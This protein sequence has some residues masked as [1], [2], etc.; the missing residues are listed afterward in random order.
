M[1]S[2]IW[3]GLG[4]IALATPL[5]LLA[6]LSGRLVRRP[7][8][9]HGLWVLV[10]LKLVTPPLGFVPVGSLDEAWPVESETSVPVFV[11][12][13][14]EGKPLAAAPVLMLPA[15][16]AAEPAPLETVSNPREDEVATQVIA[17]AQDIGDREHAPE[18]TVETA[19]LSPVAEGGESSPPDAVIGFGANFLSWL[20]PSL[21]GMWL[22]GTLV[23][24]SRVLRNSYRFQKLLAEAMI[25]PEDLK[26]RVARLAAELKVSVPKVVFVTGAISPLLWV[27]GRR[28]A[29]VLPRP[30]FEQLDAEQQGTLIVHELAHWKRGDHWVRRL[31][32]L[33]SGLYWW[34]PLVWW[35]QAGVRQAEE[36]CCDAWVTATVPGS[37]RAYALALV[38]TVDFLAGARTL[39]P[40]LA[41][42]LGPF[43]SLQRRLTMIFCKGT[44]KRLSLAGL[45]GLV[46]LGGL[47]LTWS[48]MP[49]TVRAQD[50]RPKTER[51]PLG[52]ESVGGGAASQDEQPPRPKKVKDLPGKKTPS[53][54]R[55]PDVLDDSRA[56][57]DRL[58]AELRALRDQHER[59]SRD[60][61]QRSRELQK[62][63]DEAGPGPRPGAGA[64]QAD[65]TPRPPTGRGGFNEAPPG[66][67][68]A[69]RNGGNPGFGGGPPMM[70]SANLPGN[71]V[72]RRID[73]LER[74][75][76]K[77]LQELV[78]MR[79]EMSNRGG[80]GGFGGGF[81]GGGGGS[82]FGGGGQGAGFGGGGG[83]QGGFKKGP[84]GPPPGS[85]P[86]IQPVPPREPT[87]PVA[88]T[89][90]TQRREKGNV[91]SD[92]ERDNQNPKVIRRPGAS[93]SG[94]SGQLPRPN[95]GADEGH[96][97]V[98]VAPRRVEDRGQPAKLTN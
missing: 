4:N 35:A 42:G 57:L 39:L 84:A 93:T 96:G 67:P 51:R 1:T 34:C 62:R 41:S 23:F 69:A 14:T 22:G 61:D 63:S 13:P 12:A 80:G 91:E 19:P 2:L 83:F 29:L 37:E 25:A 59:L 3:L 27:S 21:G 47:L 76:D 28:A 65:P 77:M 90:P 56:E 10:L 72:E 43:P 6:W 52:I 44:P 46:G 85:Q 70:P 89:P 81:P 82:G 98:P 64:P 78:E 20:I 15:P 92:D 86:Q 55:N 79:R 95:A 16:A 74:K 68:P 8:L 11:S 17:P 30:L 31:E 48:P 53:P 75:L 7:A 58:R 18:P 9:T 60:I 49:Q 26:A 40:T 5:A 94:G 54:G 24:W 73:N 97:I 66:F 50:D 38:E 87:P 32:C 45:F 36:E 88:P 33:A 71:P